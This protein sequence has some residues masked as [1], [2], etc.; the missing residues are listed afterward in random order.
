MKLFNNRKAD[1]EK[2][3][4]EI[5]SMVNEGNEQGLIHD[6]EVEM[7]TNIFEFSE[8]EV[9]DVMTPRS[10][11]VGIDKHT[12][13]DETIKIML[14]NNYSRYPVFDDDLDNIVGIL[15]FKDFVKAYLQDKN[16]TIEQL[17]VE[18]TFVHPTKNISELF[19]RMQKEKIHMV[20]V[21]DEYGQTEGII[22]ME[23]ILEEIVGEIN[24]EYDEKEETYTKLS[25]N[26]YIFE[27]CTL[28]N[29]FIKIVD[30]D[31]DSFKDIEGEADT[32]AGLILEIKGE[33]PGKNDVITYQSHK[34]TILE[35]YFTIYVHHVVEWF[36]FNR[37][38]SFC[39]KFGRE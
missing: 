25:N 1:E 11:V 31:Q 2:V 38:W 28:L 23:D 7:I 34:F 5:I 33:L 4:E 14:E 6:D 35:V 36:L 10:D 19:K 39:W 3:E 18:P 27:A 30:A 16:Q 26:T 15:Y 8:K 22:A 20:I 24:D 21:V 17:M 37:R 13:M 32:L 12:T 9:R 29:D